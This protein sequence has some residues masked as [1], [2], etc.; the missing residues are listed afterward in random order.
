MIVTQ[1]EFVLLEDIYENR[2]F[3]CDW[4]RV[5]THIQDEFKSWA[6]VCKDQTWD[7]PQGWDRAFHIYYKEFV[8]YLSR[9]NK[10]KENKEV[11]EE[12]VARQPITE[13]EMGVD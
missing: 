7:Y 5:P 12:F 6:G 9:L 1:A 11:E 2:S 8:G 13:T 3:L 4:S 10:I